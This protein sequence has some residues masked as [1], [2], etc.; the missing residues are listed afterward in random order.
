MFEKMVQ[1]LEQA[2][3]GLEM[4]R[5]ELGT[6]MLN[7]Y[8]TNEDL[9]TALGALE[10]QEQ[11]NSKLRRALALEKEKARQ[12]D[13]AQ[14]KLEQLKKHWSALFNVVSDDETKQ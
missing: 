14:A 12:A 2:N 5:N 11:L 3:K 13:D 1:E 4:Y 9:V 8:I 7:Q 6:T 10:T